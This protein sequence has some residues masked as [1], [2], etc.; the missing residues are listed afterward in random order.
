MTATRD[1]GI[2]GDFIHEPLNDPG[3][4]IHLMHVDLFGESDDEIECTISTH[5]V[6]D[7]P[8]YTA[9]SYTWGNM[10][11]KQTIKLNGKR[12]CIG[13]NSWLVLWQTRL[14]QLTNLLWID[15]L[16]IEQGNY[17]EKS[18]QV[19]MM[20]STYKAAVYTFVS[21]GSHADDSKLLAEQIR[22]HADFIMGQL[23]VCADRIYKLEECPLCEYQPTDLI[24]ECEDCG[25]DIYFCETCKDSLRGYHDSK[26]HRVRWVPQTKPYLQDKC[27]ECNLSI[28][29]K[30]HE[31][32][33]H[34]EG[35]LFKVCGSCAQA[36]LE[37]TNAETWKSNH[38]QLVAGGIMARPM[39]EYRD[40]QRQMQISSRLVKIPRKIHERIVDALRLL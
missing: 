21:L 3:A 31:P 36:H 15:V 33:Q 11:P 19:G 12:L 23:S 6:V 22:T 14:H 10:N 28:L 37:G 39:N 7:A 29:L 4:E 32:K 40:L 8:P 17:V 2:T 34:A 16:S 35:G 18:I 24:Y 25:D 13:Y 27:V 9:I 30:W 20:G 1:A 5:A 38:V 26:G